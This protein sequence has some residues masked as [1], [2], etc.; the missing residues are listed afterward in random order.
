MSQAVQ[1]FTELVRQAATLLAPH[2]EVPRRCPRCQQ[3]TRQ[4]VSRFRE[5][6][7]YRCVRCGGE[8]ASRETT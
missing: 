6:T 4:A 8:E 3:M 5:W 2:L 1:Q 7:Y